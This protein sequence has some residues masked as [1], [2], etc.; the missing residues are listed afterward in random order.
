MAALAGAVASA[1]AGVG[2]G[3]RSWLRHGLDALAAMAFVWF[4]WSMDD[5]D[6]TRWVVEDG[7]LEWLQAAA[8]VVVLVV[9]VVRARRGRSLV[10]AAAALVVFV[11]V[12]EELAWGSRLFSVFVPAVQGRNVQGDLTLHNIGG[13]RG[14]S[15]TFAA[16]ALVG[17]AGGL[18]VVRRRPGL[19][20][21]FWLP[22]AFCVVRVVDNDPITSR[23]AKL[24]EVLELVLYVALVRVAVIAAGGWS[25]GRPRTDGAV[26]GASG[27]GGAPLRPG[28][29]VGRLHLG[30]L[31]DLLGGERH[32]RLGLD[33]PGGTDL[34]DHGGGGD[35]VGDVGDHQHVGVAEGEVEALE[36]SAEVGEHLLD[37]LPSGGSAGG[38]DALQSVGC[39]ARLDEVLGHG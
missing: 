3:V 9:C 21:W 7:I 14:L 30:G 18:A 16:L 25:R 11:A 38:E 12:G 26:G 13:L 22:A 28:G 35:V 4:V 6:Y 10:W 36:G 20:V 32:G 5:W 33:Q 1:T 29:S 39:E 19:A 31:V 2:P 17:F 27:A 24:S 15:K 8:L 23:F 37:G 34:Q